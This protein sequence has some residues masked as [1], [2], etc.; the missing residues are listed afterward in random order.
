MANILRE[1]K[2][3]ASS[4]RIPD[5]K[6]IYHA[7]KTVRQAGCSGVTR[8]GCGTVGW[9]LVP[10]SGKRA[11]SLPRSDAPRW[12][13]SGMGRQSAKGEGPVG[14]NVQET[15]YRI[16]APEWK[17][18]PPVSEDP[19]TEPLESVCSVSQHVRQASGGV[20]EGASGPIKW[21]RINYGGLVAGCQMSRP[22]SFFLQAPIMPTARS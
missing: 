5:C 19:V 4:A 14:I 16:P 17:Q 6:A 11:G 3:A 1:R 13:E 8:L 18:K 22:K 7:V 9:H 15:R 12:C 10:I 2:E 20:R 21:A